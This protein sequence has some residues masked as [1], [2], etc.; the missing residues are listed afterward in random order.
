MSA[1]LLMGATFR[2]WF[3]QLSSQDAFPLVP[4]FAWLCE[5]PPWIDWLVAAGLCLAWLSVAAG[6]RIKLA[7]GAV[8]VLGLLSI[9]LNQHRLQPWHY[10]FLLF[11]WILSAVP[12]GFRLRWMR[13]LVVS[14]Y[15]YS[16]LSKFDFEFLHTVGQQLVAGGLR[17][18][19]VQQLLSPK[20]QFVI[21]W[22]L[23][24]FELLIA[25]GLLIPRARRYA[26][27]AACA[28]HAGLLLTLGPLGLDHSAGVLLWNV[29]FIVS[30]LLLFVVASPPETEQ[31]EEATGKVAS[32]PSLV[33]EPATGTSG[34]DSDASNPKSFAAWLAVLPLLAAL[35]L[36]V[37]ERWGGWDHWLSWALYAPH[38]SRVEVQV[39]A[40]SLARLPTRLRDMLAEQAN[41]SLWVRLP[42]AEWSLQEL[43]V[44]IYPQA[45]F[46][47]GVARFLG[48]KLDSEFEIRATILS[49]AARRDGRRT[50]KT[51][52]GKLQ[53]Q[54]MT[55]EFWFNCAPRSLPAIT[56]VSS[57]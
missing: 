4:L 19:Q 43:G 54:K 6:F 50:R 25:M 57:R 14:I 18:I 2:L 22:A 42:L 7:L 53:L 20:Q 10:Q 46:Q 1:L 16:A 39:A 33:A 24:T 34:R 13:W 38:S 52:Q 41:E 3:P 49:P 29:H 23:P 44:P 55:Q 32:Q 36:P 28:M 56:E 45:R 47:A 40:T 27:L 5:L 21:A 9:A 31:T 48:D 8:L 26:A 11:A 17:L 35:L 37:V 51:F 12:S 15:F 30:C